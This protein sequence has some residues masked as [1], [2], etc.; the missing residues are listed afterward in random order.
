[1]EKMQL[2]RRLGSENTIWEKLDLPDM[3]EEYEDY[4]I[5]HFPEPWKF[6][7]E[8]QAYKWLIEKMKCSI[9]LTEIDGTVME[10][11]GNEISEGLKSVNRG[12]CYNIG[13]CKASFAISWDLP[14]FIKRKFPDETVLQLGSTI[15]LTGS[16]LDAQ[17][18]TCAE[19]MQQVWP[20]M[21][22]TP[23][24]LCRQRWIKDEEKEYHTHVSKIFM[25]QCDLS[26][27]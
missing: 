5:T 8:S 7:T 25:P 27:L 20:T 2:W 1:M 19:Y 13:V 24:R 14:E 15:T 11:I 10:H 17:A 16:S 23:S 18:S 22:L 12:H 26:F 21:V 9:L 3:D 6:L 4:A